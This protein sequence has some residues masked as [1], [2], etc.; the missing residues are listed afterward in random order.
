MYSDVALFID[1]STDRY[2]TLFSLPPNVYLGEVHIKIDYKSTEP[3]ISQFVRIEYYHKPTDISFIILW[4]GWIRTNNNSDFIRIPLNYPLDEY[5]IPTLQ[6]T[7]D[8]TNVY[9]A[10]FLARFF[11]FEYIYNALSNYIPDNHQALY[12]NTISMKSNNAAG[13]MVLTITPAVGETFIITGWGFNFS[14]SAYGSERDVTITVDPH[15]EFIYS[16][17]DS[18]TAEMP[19]NCKS[20][21]LTYPYNLKVNVSNVENTKIAGFRLYG[22]PMSANLPD[23]SIAG[24]GTIDSQSVRIY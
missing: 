6:I 8:Y 5:D 4:E 20:F 14:L 9:T 16:L 12:S 15:K 17:N 24:D 10:N 18:D 23:V 7:I 1:G 21:R 19:H 22:Y 13:T 11:Y 2:S 3:S